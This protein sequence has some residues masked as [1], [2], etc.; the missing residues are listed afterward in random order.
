MDGD[1]RVVTILGT[2]VPPIVR[3]PLHSGNEKE[4]EMAKKSAVNKSQAIRDYMKA[5]PKA[6]PRDVVSAMS[7]KGIKVSAQF[8]STV[9]S[10]S[11]KSGGAPKRRGRPAGSTSKAG[12][13]ATSTGGATVSVDALLKMKRV[14]E[15]FG[16][17]EEA[18]SALQTLERLAK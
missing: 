18:K 4:R 2:A 3:K 8:V 17:I 16:S 9:K 5:N 14:V 13:K 6:K 1:T 7:A 15:D 11:K 10:T 12:K